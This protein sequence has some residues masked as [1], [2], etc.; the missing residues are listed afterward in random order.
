[1]K[2]QDNYSLHQISTSDTTLEFSKVLLS[3]RDN[4]N[5]EPKGLYRIAGNALVLMPSTEITPDGV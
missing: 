2:P 3:D 4:I 5:S 1:M